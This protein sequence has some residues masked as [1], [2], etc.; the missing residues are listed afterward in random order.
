MLW[1]HL[2]DF[3]IPLLQVKLVKVSS[4]EYTPSNSNSTYNQNY[5]KII[6]K[7]S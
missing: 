5:I 3:C 4:E 1:N 6:L 7:L 2:I